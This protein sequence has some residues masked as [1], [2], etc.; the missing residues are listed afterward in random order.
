MH[1]ASVAVVIPLYNHEK[2]I[3]GTLDSVLAQTMPAHEI[4]VIDDG[5]Q[6]DSA[7]IAERYAARHPS[8]RVVHQANAGAHNAINAGIAA[9]RSDYVAIL[10]SDD[11]Y[12]PERIERCRA[13]LATRPEI[14]AVATALEFMNDADKALD[15]A[16]Y[17]QA[18]DY[19][20]KEDDLALGLLNGNFIMTTSNLVARRSLFAAIGTFRALRYAH[21]LDFFLRIP[22]AGRRLHWLDQPLAKYRLHANN[23]IKE[24]GRKVRLEWAAIVAWYLRAVFR[25]RQTGEDAWARHEKILK[26]IERHNL[27]SLVLLFMGFFDAQP[28]MQCGSD[29][30]L[31]DPAFHQRMLGLA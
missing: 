14:D 23:T 12:H 4:I 2:F 16:W 18:L 15:N 8:L 17:A 27:A 20:R 9:A 24:D 22:L 3:A 5:S 30:F 11:A 6:D 25:R 26:I 21:D 29:A 31:Q 13:V 28:D 19:Y 1:H 10:N 7:A